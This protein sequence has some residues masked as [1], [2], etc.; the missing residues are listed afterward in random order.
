MIMGLRW[1][2]MRVGRRWVNECWPGNYVFVVDSNIIIVAVNVPL[3]IHTMGIVLDDMDNHVS[4]KM[5]NAL[6][7]VLGLQV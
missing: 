5:T 2:V 4:D 3:T 7:H 6:M 1:F